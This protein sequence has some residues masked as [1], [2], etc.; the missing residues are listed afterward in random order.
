[1]LYIYDIMYKIVAVNLI[2]SKQDHLKRPCNGYRSLT[3]DPAM[4]ERPPMDNE[5]DARENHYQNEA[6]E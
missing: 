1:M 4:T 6:G 5:D 2:S 3:E